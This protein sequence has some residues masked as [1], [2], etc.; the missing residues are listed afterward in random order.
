MLA[1]THSTGYTWLYLRQNVRDVGL[2][3]RSEREAAL[4]EE[5][6]RCPN[7]DENRFVDDE[8]PIVELVR[9]LDR[10]RVAMLRIELR[11]IYGMEEVLAVVLHNEH[12]HAWALLRDER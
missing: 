12:R 1:S 10:E 3:E 7:M 11:D 4:S 2:V 9:L 6:E 8:E 5:I